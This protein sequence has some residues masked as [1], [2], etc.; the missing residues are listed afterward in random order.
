MEP[1]YVAADGSARIFYATVSGIL[2][3]AIFGDHVSPISDTTVLSCV[4]TECNLLKHVKTQFPYA[5]IVAL[6]SILL[7][8]IPIG[9]SS[10]AP[11]ALMIIIAILAIA[12]CVR[13]IGVP[14][15]NDSGDFDIFTELYLFISKSPDLVTLKT[16]TKN[17]GSSAPKSVEQEEEIEDLKAVSEK[18]VEDKDADIES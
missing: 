7:G 18:E 3:G 8:T 10:K 11:N 14:T 1:T 13:F 6:W 5:L 16:D 4:A 9:Y 2:A 12:V 15:V 17:F